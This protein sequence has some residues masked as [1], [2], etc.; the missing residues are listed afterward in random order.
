MSTV[1]VLIIINLTSLVFSSG[2]Q[3]AN[4]LMVMKHI[5]GERR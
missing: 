5:K 1:S 4:S 2:M 3:I